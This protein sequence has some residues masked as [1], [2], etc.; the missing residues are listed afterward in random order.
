MRE[1][2]SENMMLVDQYAYYGLDAEG[3]QSESIKFLLKGTSL[4]SFEEFAK[5][6][7]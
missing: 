3:K 1:E 5:A 7:W 6:A 4:T 2:M